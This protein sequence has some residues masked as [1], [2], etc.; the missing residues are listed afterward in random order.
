ML[1]KYD[2][3]RLHDGMNDAGGEEVFFVSNPAL[4]LWAHRNRFLA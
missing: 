2:P 3:A 4:G 1:K